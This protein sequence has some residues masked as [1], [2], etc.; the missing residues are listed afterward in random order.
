MKL[1]IYGNWRWLQ[2]DADEA[3]T[4]EEEEAFYREYE[5]IF[6]EEIDQAKCFHEQE[7]ARADVE[8]VD[9]GGF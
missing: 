5:R 3:P 1:H 8:I 2:T 6:A 7:M 4:E 9:G